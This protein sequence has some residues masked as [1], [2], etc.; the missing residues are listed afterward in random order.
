MRYVLRFEGEPAPG[1]CETHGGFQSVLRRTS[2][3]KATGVLAAFCPECEQAGVENGEPTLPL[4]TLPRLAAVFRD[5]EEPKPSGT[6][7]RVTTFPGALDAL[8]LA[9]YA[10]SVERAPFSRS[11]IF[12]DEFRRLEA[13]NPDAL[14]ERLVGLLLAN[15]VIRREKK[16][17]IT[18]HLPEDVASGVDVMAERVGLYR[19]DTVL[20]VCLSSLLRANGE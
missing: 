18:L 12:A 4:Q 19:P 13:M 14:A 2:L 6:I 20:A 8:D 11:R 9:C 7:I 5:A 10:D 15:E 17:S 16:R 1:L 3:G